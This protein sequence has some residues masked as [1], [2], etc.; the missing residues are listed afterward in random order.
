M[1]VLSLLQ[2]WASL[3][4]MGAKTIETRGWT[5][6]YRGPLLIHASKGK[7]GA[8]LAARPPFNKYIGEFKELPFGAIVG[9]VYLDNILR[10]ELLDLP[11]YRIN[12]LSLEEYAFGDY[13]AGRYGWLL[14]DPVLF[15][16][17]IAGPGQLGLWDFPDEWVPV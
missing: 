1:K 5:S 17:P 14:S 10:V 3:V 11:E 2:P 6:K 16:E 9:K 15:R 7:A 8:A 12:Q 13:T 4:V